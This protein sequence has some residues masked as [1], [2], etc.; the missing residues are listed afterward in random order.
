M[1]ERNG[2][3]PGSGLSN[4]APLSENA[5]TIART[6]ALAQLR[7]ATWEATQWCGLTEIE[8]FVGAVLDEIESDAP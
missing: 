2:F 4:T 7:Q 3:A 6:R 1:P 8:N 5:R